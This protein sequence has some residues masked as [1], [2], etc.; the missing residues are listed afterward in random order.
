[1]KAARALWRDSKGSVLV[2]ATVLAPLLFALILGVFEFS[3]IFFQQQLIEIGVRD[4]ARYMARIPITST[5]T[6]PDTNPC[7]QTDA[8]GTSFTTYAGNIALYG[9]TSSGTQRVTGWTGPVTITCP[10]TDNSAGTYA[11]ATTIYTIT[12]TTSFTDPTLGFLGFLGLGAPSISVTH[13]ER[14]IGPG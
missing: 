6:P 12:A 13:N 11:D 10:T 5:A 9:T 4:A 14:F 7:D 8:S 3:W 1:M 2:E